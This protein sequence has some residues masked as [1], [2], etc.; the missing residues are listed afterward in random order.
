MASKRSCPAIGGMIS[1]VDCGAQR[2]SKLKC[3]PHC[4]YFPFGTDAYDSWLKIDGEWIRKV[5]NYLRQKIGP[6]AMDELIQRFALRT[7]ESEE[8]IESGFYGAIY[9]GL[10][11]YRDAD[12]HTLADSWES[13]GWSGLNNDER[14]MM[15]Y[16]R[17]SFVTIIEIQRI[18][19]EKALECIDLLRPKELETFTL[20]DRLTAAT[21]VRFDQILVWL[22]H[23][24]HFSRIGG[25]GIP[26]PVLLRDRAVK[27]VRAMAEKHV[28]AD[29]NIHD[30]LARHFVE[31]VELL[32]KMQHDYMVSM[33]R[34]MDANHAVATYRLNA[35]VREVRAVLESKPEFELMD[36]C[37]APADDQKVADYVWLRKGESKQIEE[38]LP[39]PFRHDD[40]EPA[41]GTIGNVKLL[42]DRLV[43]ET[44]SRLKQEFAKETLERYLGNRIAFEKE[45]I[46]DLGQQ[47]A[48]RIESGE[49][50]DDGRVQW[51]EVSEPPGASK[52]DFGA[53][54]SVPLTKETRQQMVER[55]YRTHYEK[56]LVDS[57]PAL[58]NATPVTAARDPLLRARLVELMKGHIQ[59][60][61]TNARKDGLNLN[62]GWVIDRL[63]LH[64]LK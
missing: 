19:N 36:D 48:D 44:F 24:P 17:R 35:P 37:D 56:F 34:R 21:A 50:G 33:F 62:I 8:D 59:S 32:W 47:M 39:N 11:F 15:R 53:G 45:S 10:I 38:A 9:Y 1:A 52:P 55:F 40:D 16:R 41:I 6:R 7:E 27:A 30:C 20:F 25:I 23:Y 43:L 12:G 57:I 14:V 51:Q 4:P 49:E 5:A 13:E 26:I 42:A 46:T 64:E 58:D 61:E 54:S 3:P 31:A 2:G 22:T 63:G 29:C 60:V 28:T 18:L